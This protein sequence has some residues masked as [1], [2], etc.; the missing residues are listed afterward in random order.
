M[1]THYPKPAI[2]PARQLSRLEHQHFHA[3]DTGTG[4]HRRMY[5]ALVGEF[6]AR[7]GLLVS[8]LPFALS[9]LATNTAGKGAWG[10]PYRFPACDHPVYFHRQR[11]ATLVLIEPYESTDVGGLEEYAAARGLMLHQPPNPMASFHFPGWTLAIAIT[12]PNFGPV[13]WLP[14]QLAFP[15]RGMVS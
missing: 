11:R 10:L 1:D 14:D 9:T 5:D 13:T 4:H 8:P 12:R 6:A 3:T 2:L 15:W 7:N